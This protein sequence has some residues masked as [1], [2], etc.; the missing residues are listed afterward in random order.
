VVLM[1]ATFFNAKKFN[2]NIS[3]W[4]ISSVSSTSLMFHNAEAFDQCL[5]WSLNTDTYTRT[6]FVGSGGRMSSKC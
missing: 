2:R 3:A 5:E 1:Y 6:M 4:E